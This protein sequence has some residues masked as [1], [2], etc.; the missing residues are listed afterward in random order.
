M[1]PGL[2]FLSSLACSVLYASISQH[3]RWL[4]SVE[5]H[6]H[7]IEILFTTIDVVRFKMVGLNDASE[8]EEEDEGGEEGESGEEG[9]PTHLALY[10]EDL[11]TMQ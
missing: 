8:D 7:S 11:A 5:V 1:N 4:L 2:S 10:T 3:L 6:L 9:F